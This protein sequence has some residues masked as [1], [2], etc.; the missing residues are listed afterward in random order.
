MSKVKTTLVFQHLLKAQEQG[1]KL[2][3]AQGGSRSG[4][5]VNILIFWI[6]KL[7]QEQNKTIIE[8]IIILLKR[9]DRERKYNLVIVL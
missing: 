8:A 3:V 1:K 5:T 2:V 4:K 6:Q 9:I 7:L